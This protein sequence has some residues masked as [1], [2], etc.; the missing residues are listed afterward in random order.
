MTGRSRSLWAYARKRTEW[1]LGF[2]TF[3]FLFERLL[4]SYD[5]S[6]QR[7]SLVYTPL[8]YSSRFFRFFFFSHPGVDALHSMIW[9]RMALADDTRPLSTVGTV[10]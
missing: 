1:D 4:A 6:A 5:G 3:R 2:T 8:P 7:D 9:H 10:R